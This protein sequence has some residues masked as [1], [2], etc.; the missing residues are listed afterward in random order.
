MSDK[1]REL[2]EIG[3]ITAVNTLLAEGALDKFNQ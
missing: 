2:I 1:V 3:V